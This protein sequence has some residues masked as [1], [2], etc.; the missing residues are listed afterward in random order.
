[1]TKSPNFL[2]IPTVEGFGKEWETFD[3]KGVRASELRAV[4]SKYF[5][6]FPWTKLPHNSVG[7]D[8]GCGSGRW[9]SF[10]APLVG[11]LW[12]VDPSQA[13]LAVARQA[14]DQAGNIRLVSAAA[15]TLPFADARLDF[16]YSI[17]VL[18]HVPD[19]YTALADCVRTL[20]PGAPLL[21]YLYYA[22]DNRP[23]W[24]RALWRISDLIRRNLSRAPYPMRYWVSQGLAAAVYFPMARLARH[25]ERLVGEKVDLIPLSAYRHR[26]FYMMRNDAL[27]RFGTPLEQRFTAREVMDMMT[28]AGL[29]DVT[30]GE[31]GPYWCAIGYRA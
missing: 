10:V 13:A 20:K 15:G 19:T 1:M 5:V 21:V 8:I 3:Q 17:G 25:A 22:F 9:A 18:H 7:A 6:M 11:K 23:A 27:D 16:A 12:C 28:Q 31:E 30:L 2:H 24:F 4:W 14:T 26:P 29:R